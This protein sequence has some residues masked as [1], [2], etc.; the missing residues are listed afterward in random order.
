MLTEKDKVYQYLIFMYSTQLNCVS[1]DGTLQQTVLT[2]RCSS[3]PWF[4]QEFALR[5]QIP[6]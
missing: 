6:I 2:F 3:I 1:K 4:A 5:N